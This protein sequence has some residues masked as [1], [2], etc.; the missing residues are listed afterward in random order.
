[1]RFFA[2]LRM[3]RGLRLGKAIERPFRFASLRTIWRLNSSMSI[4]RLFRVACMAALGVVALWACNAMGE[5]PNPESIHGDRGA[6]PLYRQWTVAETHH[7]ADWL[8]HIYLVK[9]H[10]SQVQRLAKLEGVLTDPET[11]LLLDPAFAG[12][13]CN[14]QLDIATIRSLHCVV[15]CAKL[16][17]S[18]S[19][20]Y[21]YRRGLP[22]M[23]SYVRACDGS[24]VRTAAYTVPGGSAS[25]LDYKSPHDFFLDA[26]RGT[27]TGNFRVELNR[28]NSD[29]SDTLPVAIDRAHLLPGCMYYLDGHVLILATIDRYGE[30]RFL[31]ATTAASRDIYTHNGF[32]AVTGI[33][34]GAPSNPGDYSGCYRGFRVHRFPIAETDKDGEVKKIRWRTDDEMREFGFSTEEYDKLRELL[35]NGKI[36]E[37]GVSLDSFHA[38][39]RLRLRTAERIALADDIQACADRLIE[40][41]RMREDRVQQAWRGV[42]ENGPIPFPEGCDSEN[43]FN[44]GGRWGAD[45]TATFDLDIRNEYFALLNCIDEAIPWY[46]LT[47]N[48]LDLDALNKHAIWTKADYADAALRAKQRIF[49]DTVFEYTN[50]AGNQTRLTLLDLEQ[51]LYDLSFDPNQPPELR[52]GAAPGSVEAQTAPEMPTPLPNGKTVAMADAYQREAYYRSLMQRETDQSYLSKMFTGGFPVRQKLDDTI[53]GKW[54]GAPSPPLVP[55][56]GRFAWLQQ[57]G[58]DVARPTS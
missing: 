53:R 26:V 11:N 2:S 44:A 17:V 7:F 32:N 6:W 54:F 29:R 38:F 9:S 13:P 46:D 4:R 23:I 45:S 28:A 47:P 39:I 49:G 12:D 22:W 3:T 55:H 40:M 20:Y 58:Q 41:L 24:D 10:G 42:R 21:A 5:D 25:C 34:T 35:A 8:E 27:C 43:V 36:V 15:D 30:P 14:P 56:N 33:T 1:M 16:T 48:Y 18:L 31:D 52:W 51:R 57:Q 19:M 50:S 37:N